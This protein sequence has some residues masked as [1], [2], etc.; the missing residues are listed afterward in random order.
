MAVANCVGKP[1]PDLDV[2]M[3]V[4]VEGLEDV[5]ATGDIFLFSGYGASTKMIQVATNSVWDH[6]GMV[7]RF[8]SNA[9]SKVFILEY[10]SGVHLYPL[11]GR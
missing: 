2:A 4:D 10:T 1:D 5:V 8:P 3:P 7:V 6:I 11:C 9:G